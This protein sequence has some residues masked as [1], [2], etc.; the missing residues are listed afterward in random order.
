MYVVMVAAECSPVVQ[1]GGLA[2]VVSGLTRELELRGNSVEIILPKYDC[3]RYDRVWGLTL[4]YRDLWVPWYG[5]A[6]HCSV[7]FGFVNGRK[8]FFIEPHSQDNFFDRPQAYG[9][10]DDVMRYAFFS[11]AALEFMLKANKRPD[12]IHCHDWQTALVPVLLFEIYKYCGLANQRVCFT[13]HNF[14][15]QGRVGGEVLRA[16]GLKRPEYYFH[17]DRLR[18]NAH[19]GALNVLKGGIV[20]SNFVTTVSPRHAWEVMNTDQGSGLGSTL[21]THHAKFGGVLN[22]ID[23]EGR[24]PR[25]RWRDR[26]PLFRELDGSEVENKRA[27]RDRFWLRDGFKP[28]VAYVGRL[29]HPKGS[30]YRYFVRHA[31]FYSLANGGQFVLVGP[32]PDPSINGE[33]WHLKHYLNDN[34]DCHLE[35]NFDPDVVHL[36]YAGADMVVHAKQVRAVRAGSDDRHEIRCGAHCAGR[37]RA[38]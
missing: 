17:H 11:K 15:H 9:Y 4:D 14:A 23:Y 38:G 12:V 16:T 13:V 28:I 10:N 2:D 34:P 7:Y 1:M 33:F 6:I 5:G 24:D 26:Q 21:R 18:D 19:P 37:W 8:C 32:S 20:Y 22:G 30:A 25:D 29:N 27:L 3:M 31:L 35:L 36:V